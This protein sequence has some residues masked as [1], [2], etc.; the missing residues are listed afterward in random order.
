LNKLP[1][2]NN[3]PDSGRFRNANGVYM[4]L[5]NF[6]RFD[7]TYSGE[8][9]KAG[10]KLEEEIWDEFASDTPRLRKIA[11]GIVDSLRKSIDGTQ[12]L[13]PDE[14]E[15]F[16][17]GKVLYQQHRIRERNKQKVKAFKEMA[18]RNGTIHCSI[19]GFSFYKV[20]E[21]LGEDFIECHH[22]IPVSEYGENTKTRLKDLV[23]VCS[24][25]HRMLH[26]KRPWLSI[27]ELKAIINANK[28]KTV[29]E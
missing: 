27:E 20:Y 25:C 14:A 29:T 17:E 8:G 16:P 12:N 22:T 21:E 18:K 4:K 19:C 6:L 9:L 1:I 26:K 7:P 23:L 24:N 28:I 3:R 10:G 13:E 15:E 11:K 2:H 5:C